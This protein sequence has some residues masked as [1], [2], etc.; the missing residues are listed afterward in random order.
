VVNA[1]VHT[2]TGDDEIGV[3][4]AKSAGEALGNIRS[5]EGMRWFGEAGYSFGREAEGDD[6][7]GL[8]VEA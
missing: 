7:G 8:S 4:F 2:V 1:I 3:D 5:G 6:F